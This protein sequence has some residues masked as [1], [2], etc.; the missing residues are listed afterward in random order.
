MAEAFEEV[1]NKKSARAALEN[2]KERILSGEWDKSLR[3]A[4]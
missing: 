1:T 2:L 4:N 3:A